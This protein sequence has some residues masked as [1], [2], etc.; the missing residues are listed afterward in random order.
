M[1]WAGPWCT[2]LPDSVL[3]DR[4]NP[5]S[6][7]KI[8]SWYPGAGEPWP[9]WIPSV[10]LQP[11]LPHSLLLNL[12]QLA[13]QHFHIKVSLK[14]CGLWGK[15]CGRASLGWEGLELL[16]LRALCRAV[17]LAFCGGIFACG[18]S[19][20]ACDRTP[21][22]RPPDV[23]HLGSGWLYLATLA[24]PPFPLQ[25]L[26]LFCPAVMRVWSL[27]AFVTTFSLTFS[28]N[29]RPPSRALPI[30]RL[31]LGVLSTLFCCLN[32]LGL[33]HGFPQVAFLA[34]VTQ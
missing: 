18:A 11:G 17:G 12:P 7:L 8:S 16:H 34:P 2:F 26:L 19:G 21:A 32:I 15:A 24:F 14:F 29:S 1:L 4:W 5:A 27:I 28:R 13:C 22:V 30:G 6:S 10:P 33:P 23:L 20:P 3:F 25:S 31:S 9:S